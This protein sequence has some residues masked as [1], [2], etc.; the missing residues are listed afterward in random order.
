RFS[1]KAALERLVGTADDQTVRDLVDCLDDANPSATTLKGTHVP[2]GVICYEAL[3]QIAY[4]EPTDPNGDV[5]R[6]WSGHVQPTATLTELPAA[7]RAWTE[8]V[9]KKAYR[10]L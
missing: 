4:Y 9:K 7:K 10:R 6:Q 8:V 5:A 2:V 1:D 3:T